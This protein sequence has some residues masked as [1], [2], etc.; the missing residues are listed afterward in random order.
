MKRIH[1]EP[2]YQADPFRNQVNGSL[3]TCEFQE[4]EQVVISDTTNSRNLRLSR[5]VTSIKRFIHARNA[6]HLHLRNLHMTSIDDHR[7][8]GIRKTIVITHVGKTN[9]L[10]RSR[11]MDGPGVH[12]NV[13]FSSNPQTWHYLLE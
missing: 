4:S 6:Q 9:K 12:S 2:A 10:T 13:A 8:Q 1:W 3:R 11:R 5:S 7:N